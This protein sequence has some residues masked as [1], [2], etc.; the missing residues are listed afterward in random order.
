DDGGDGYGRIVV[1]GKQRPAHRVS[2]EHFVGPI[3]DG[4]LLDHLCRV[5]CCIN[6]AH[7]EPVTSGENTR[8]GFVGS[9]RHE[10]CKRGHDLSQ[11]A[12]TRK[13]GSRFCRVCANEAKRLS[14]VR[15]GRPPE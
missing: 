7:L 14:Y 6:P 15:K 9:E 13:D 1:G 5:R 10:T 11:T 2:Y 4:L 12:A 3:P 8:R